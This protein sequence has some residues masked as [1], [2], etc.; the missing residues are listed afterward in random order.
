M[1]CY[2][3]ELRERSDFGDDHDGYAVVVVVVVRQGGD[4]P[5]SLI[6]RSCGEMMT[7]LRA[8]LIVFDHPN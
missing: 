2:L 1:T 3:V 4:H 6:Y 8:S 7:K 5:G